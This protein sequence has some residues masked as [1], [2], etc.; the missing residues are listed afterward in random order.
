MKISIND[1][2]RIKK[3]V[4]IAIVT[5]RQALT[6][7]VIYG[8]TIEDGITV[9]EDKA[10]FIDVYRKLE[11]LHRLSEDISDILDSFNLTNHI[12]SLVRSIKNLTYM[13][14]IS[15][16]ALNKFNDSIKTK[17][18][19][20]ANGDRKPVI[21]EFKGYFRKKDFN[22]RYITI[23]QNQ[24]RTLQSQLDKLNVEE[25]ELPYTYEQ[26]DTLTTE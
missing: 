21:Y 17:M 4:G 11:A 12:P 23:L 5:T 15:V 24:I 19:N 16:N 6:Y 1:L 18:V 25:V 8:Q 20:L 2:M 7:D 13:K 14:D 3:Q 9:T 10:Q 26:I 22:D